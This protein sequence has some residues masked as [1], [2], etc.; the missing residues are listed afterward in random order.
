MPCQN[1]PQ[2]WAG[3]PWLWCMG[4]EIDIELFSNGITSLIFGYSNVQA[5]PQ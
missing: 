4:S 2:P 5:A 1:R 3:Q